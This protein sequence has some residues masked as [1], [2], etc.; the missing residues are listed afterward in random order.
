MEEYGSLIVVKVLFISFNNLCA[1]PPGNVHGG[2]TATTLDS[3]IGY[4]VLRAIG[5][6][7]VTLNL[8]VNYRKV[9][10]VIPSNF[11]K[12]IKLGSV[13]RVECKV[14]KRDGRKVYL[15]GK[16]TDGNDTEIYAEADALFYRVKCVALQSNFS[17]LKNK[18]SISKKHTKH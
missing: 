6:G 8:N 16:L 13:V 1:G 3:C 12:F 17:S 11:P 4:C 9:I 2:A 18:I 5:F 15:Y 10:F 7:F 14:T